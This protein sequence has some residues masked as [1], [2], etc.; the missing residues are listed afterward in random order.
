MVVAELVRRQR[1]QAY[2][3]FHAFGLQDADDAELPV[4]FPDEFADVRHRREPRPKTVS[5]AARTSRPD[6]PAQ[7][8]PVCNSFTS[9][10]S[11][12]RWRGSPPR[13]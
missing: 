12:W 13:R 10:S 2:R 6:P 11:W 8:P 3:G 7:P 1:V 9:R 5:S 4:L